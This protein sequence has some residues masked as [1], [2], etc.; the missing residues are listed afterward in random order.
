MAAPPGGPPGPRPAPGAPAPGPP[1][2]APPAAPPPGPPAP[3]PGRGP[4]NSV[5][6]SFDA[7]PFGITT[8]IGTALPSA[9]RLSRIA[10]LLPGPG[11]CVS[12]PPMPCSKYRTGYFWSA[13]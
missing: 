13:E 5:D 10:P 6:G 1:G 2:G 12:L 7:R 11:Q 3:A 4:A 8:I 9:I